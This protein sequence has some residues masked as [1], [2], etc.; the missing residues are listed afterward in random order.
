[1][2]TIFGMPNLE[3][4]TSS[5]QLLDEVLEMYAAKSIVDYNHNPA[6]T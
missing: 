6:A 5:A 1:M 4:P 3:P 2:T